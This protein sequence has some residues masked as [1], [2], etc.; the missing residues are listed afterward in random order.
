[1]NGK[2][3]GQVRPLSFSVLTYTTGCLLII[4]SLKIWLILEFFL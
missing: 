2:Y 1:M 3:V 4:E